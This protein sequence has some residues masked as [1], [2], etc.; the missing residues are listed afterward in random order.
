MASWQRKV[1]IRTA[2]GARQEPHQLQRG[3]PSVDATAESAHEGL[4]WECQ[5][6]REGGE[7]LKKRRPRQLLTDGPAYCSPAAP[8]R[9]RCRELFARPTR[10]GSGACRP[11][12]CALS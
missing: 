12:R 6:L 5:A 2:Q 9:N 3:A 4:C 11:V 7:T 8:I 1:E 10:S